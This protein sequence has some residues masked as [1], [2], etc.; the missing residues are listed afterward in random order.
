MKF[1]AKNI[2]GLLDAPSGRRIGD[3]FRLEIV[4]DTGSTSG[5]FMEV[6]PG[7]G[8]KG[9]VLQADFEPVSGEV[10]DAVNRELFVHEC[11]FVERALN[12]QEKTAPFFVSADFLIA[13]ALIETDITNAGPKFL[14]S[15]A[16]GPLQVSSDE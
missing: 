6:D 1:R 14:G 13:R 4:T 9:W 11:I 5:A 8:T 15:D 3:I 10:R 12:D 16:T 2:T 7:D